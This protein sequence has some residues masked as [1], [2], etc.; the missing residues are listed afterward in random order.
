MN[1]F[2]IYSKKAAHII[3]IYSICVISILLIVFVNNFYYKNFEP[4]NIYHYVINAIVILL[5]IFLYIYPSKI[6]LISVCAGIY[7]IVCLSVPSNPMGLFM[8][9][10]AFLSLY[11]RGYYKK[12]KRVK[13]ILTFLLFP[14]LVLPTLK[15]GFELFVLSMIDYAGYLFT[16]SCVLYLYTQIF[17][18]DNHKKEKALNIAFYDDL[19]ERDCQ[20]LNKIQ[21]KIKYNTIA[22]EDSLTVGT[23][24]NRLK[25]IYD[26]LEVGDKSGFLSKYEDYK[27]YYDRSEEKVEE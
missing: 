17:L 11:L 10:L 2:S 20:W 18:M 19:N 5:T 22:I 14:I 1:K 9:L 24:K 6:E 15:H 16:S 23:V 3:R 7:S 25:V 13:I 21:Q 27:I 8:Y 4:A 26:A 12:H